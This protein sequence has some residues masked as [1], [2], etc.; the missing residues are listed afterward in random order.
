MNINDS[1]REAELRA[2][3]RDW[4]AS[5]VPAS[6]KGRRH[7][8]LAD[9]VPR[10]EEW[11]PLLN[12][13]ERKGWLAP[14]WPRQHG[15]AGFGVGEM[16]VFNEEW[17]HAG[18]PNYRS[19][20]LDKIGPT[21][22]ETG[23]P[24]QQARFLEPTRR[25]EIIWA[26]GYS[27]PGAGSDL[28]SLA[29]RADR[30]EGGFSLT[31]S[32]IWTSNGHHADWLYVLARTDPDAKPRHAGISMMILDAKTPGVV[33]TPIIAI[34]GFHEFNQTFFDGAFVPE[35]QVV[36][37]LNDGWRVSNILLGYERFSH[38]AGNPQYHE[39]AMAQLKRD[40]RELPRGNGTVWDDKGLQ[41]K[42]AQLEMEIDCLRAIRYRA[43]TQISQAGRPGPEASIFKF[44]GG[45]L[46][47]RIIELHQHVVGSA[48]AVWEAEPFGQH[49]RDLARKDAKA[50]SYTIAGGT[51]EIQRN[52][53]AKRI[54]GMP[55][56]T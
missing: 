14:A 4:I 47:Q 29:L 25:R 26:Q 22:I 44:H 38:P 18:L 12:A 9:E 13:L 33:L 37:P 55:D 21:I 46:M 32:K 54:L 45:E 53:V 39:A 11:Q 6:L 5:E 24:E 30:V 36:G 40:A 31:G 50:R 23:S 56:P 41:R 42:V 43:Q 51:K 15:G 8:L 20:G 1:P 2:E 34:D 16:I 3:L 7:T 35:A 17:I 27:E 49:L 52:I 19:D 28:A 48:A 10:R